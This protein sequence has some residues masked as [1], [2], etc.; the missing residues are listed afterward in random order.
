MKKWLT[1]NGFLLF[2]LGAAILAV[3]ATVAAL[4]DGTHRQC[5]RRWIEIRQ[6]DGVVVGRFAA[7]GEVHN[8][9]GDLSWQDDDGVE[10]RFILG[11]CSVLFEPRDVE[12]K[13]D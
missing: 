2:P 10:H 12:E 5:A 13:E 6:P 11:A 1:N 3:V 4:L 9:H 8:F 7:K